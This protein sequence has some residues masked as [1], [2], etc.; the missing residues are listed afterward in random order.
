MKNLSYQF[1]RK[2]K[3]AVV[4]SGGG[5]RGLAHIGVLK[6]LE[7]H[8]IPIDLIVGTSI[9]SLV[10]GFYAAGYSPEGLQR[11]LKTIDWENIFSEEVYRTNLFWSQKSEPR[12]HVLELRFDKGI[13]YIP[14]SL[15]QGQKIFDLIYSSLLKANFQAANNFD[16][17][18]IPFRA[19]ATDLVSGKKVVLKN[20]NLAEAISA[21]LTYPLIFAPVEWDG[22]L[23]VDGGIRD[24]LPV[25][26][27]VEA[28]ANLTL[29]VDVTSPLHAS[30]DLQSPLKLADQV[31][32]IMMREPTLESRK[33]ADVLIEPEVGTHGATDFSQIDSLIK[34][35]YNA[36]IQMMDSIKKIVTR[37]QNTF[38]GPNEY[39]GKVGEVKISG[40]VNTG[41][42]T[43]IR[44]MVTRSGY[45]LYLYDLYQ[46]LH[47][48]YDSGLLSHAS[49]VL[50]GEPSAYIV[51][52]RLQENPVV[53]QVV[54][55]GV[56]L[57]PESVIHE[58]I[59]IPLNE[60]LN[61]KRLFSAIE[62][63]RNFYIQS[64]YSLARI[65]EVRWEPVSGQIILVIDEGRI[66]KIEAVG[67]KITKDNIIFRE[68]PLREG[69]VFNARAV[70]E[71]IRNIH[72]TR[73]FDRV[74]L[75]VR[76]RQT[77]SDLIIK[78]KEKK[79]FLMRLG[80]NASLERK[81]KVF[82][83]FAE[84][85]L[86]GRGL[87]ASV[88]GSIGELERNAE[89]R[90]FTVRLFNTLLTTRLSLYYKER[91]DRFYQNYLRRG[92]Y[93]SIRRGAR[94]ILGQQIERLGSITAEVRIDGISVHS[95]EELFPHRG[96]YRIR[97]LV[98][99]SI[100]DKRDKLPFPDK[101]I[102]NRWFWETGNQR[103]L[104]GTEA[105]TRFHIALE[106]YYPFYDSFNYHIK[107]AGGSADLT[108]PFPEFYDLGGMREFPGLYERE[109]F[110]RQMV[111]LQNE[112]RY[113][114]KWRL[115][116]EFYVGLNYN[117]GAVW[118]TSE[119]PIQKQD[120]LTSV[121]GFLAVNSVF[122]PIW[123]GYG[124]LT[125]KRDLLYFSV[126]YEF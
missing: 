114:I 117:I 126:G 72:S 17:L 110:G 95:A 99:R 81:G 60:V 39:L 36:T 35:G 91:W 48:F 21:S 34:I 11:I 31:T 45:S 76:R 79:Y 96:R 101:G 68:F 27:A 15:T 28:G 41:L 7:K 102:Y 113:K 125:G 53:K 43:L 40:L 32:T 58:I 67:N 71:G 33:M 64:G 66:G 62:K 61:F 118:K 78:V 18:R 85:N 93:L 54:V 8:Q 6:A 104:G 75:N 44:D 47:L 29:A 2:L 120:F 20:G 42:D 88:W 38:W 89:F 14:S 51:E 80:G 121:G 65:L 106:G 92:D 69:E 12:R 57:Y 105:F 103:I 122:G 98:F 109:Q 82:L 123:L 24:N 56:Q 59:Q 119:E 4:L 23:L 97:S 26:V 50:Q 108:L 13:P 77:V 74:T 49:V 70:V 3:I 94:F 84:D 124:H 9:G 63:L 5:A 52:F 111:Y 87:K 90:V 107:A 116:I 30:E 1:P 10:G 25:D 83:E 22:M 46:D 73:L 19:V 86:F 55:E 16:N 37:K 100:V 112:L 115:P